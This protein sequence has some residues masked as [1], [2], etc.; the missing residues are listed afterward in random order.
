MAEPRS[1]L[2]K[3]FVAGDHGNHA[4]G[5]GVTLRERKNLS[6]IQ[7]TA[8]ADSIPAVLTAIGSA[9]GLVLQNK[10]GLGRVAGEKSVFGFA[11]GRYFVVS[12]T[13]DLETRLRSAISA[14]LGTMV[15]LTHGRTVIRIGGPRSEWVISKLF[16]IDFSEHA[17]PVAY[18]R[19]TLHHDIHTNIQR[20]DDETF[21]LYVFRTFA[22]SFWLTLGH[23]AEEVG[24]R[25]E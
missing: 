7:I 24:Y 5:I 6:I 18:G 14:E 17:F 21:D 10:P 13:P 19:A 1:P 16:A 8:W 20:I 12:A 9:T 15:D 23:A 22:R 25:V 11:P 2:G 4:A 3:A